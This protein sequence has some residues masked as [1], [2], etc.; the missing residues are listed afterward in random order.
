[1][2][3]SPS[4]PF[5]APE[6]NGIGG[7]RQGRGL[8]VLGIQIFDGK[9]WGTECLAHLGTPGHDFFPR[10]LFRYSFLM[11]ECQIEISGGERQKRGRKGK[12]I[13][14]RND[15]ESEIPLAR[16]SASQPDQEIGGDRKNRCG[17]HTKQKSR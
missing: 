5:F 9:G 2:V 12:P 16:I 8:V 7:V 1:M 11:I 14:S 17:S 15:V 10:P 3:P 4:L 13:K 6:Y